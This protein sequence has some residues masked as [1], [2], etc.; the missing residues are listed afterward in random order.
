[1]KAFNQIAI[2]H[3]DIRE[4]RLTMDIFAADLWQ[5]VKGTAPR[6]YQ[7]PD[8]FFRKTHIT[9]GLKNILLQ[10]RDLREGVEMPLSNYIHPLGEVKPIH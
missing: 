8:V 4:G 9:K 7:D 2:P 6:D 5:V 1:M 3:E 10:N